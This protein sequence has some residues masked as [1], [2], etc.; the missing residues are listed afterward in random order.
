VFDDGSGAALY[1]GGSFTV[2]GGTP[3][4]RI[5]KWD[6][7]S[8]SAVGSGTSG[9]V[10]ALTVFDDGSGPALYA[11]GFFSLAGGVPANAIARW[12]GSSWSALGQG[13]GNGVQG[14]ISALATFDD[15]SGPA[16]YVGG[17]FTEAG[18]VP[19]NSIAR[20]DGTS[21]TALGPGV[22]GSFPAVYSLTVFDDGSGSALYVGGEFTQAGANPAG[23][24]ARWDGVSWS[25]VGSGM[26]LGSVRQLESFDDG[27]GAKLY[28]GGLFW[29]EQGSGSTFIAS[30]DGTSWSPLAAGGVNDTVEALFSYQ[31]GSE[32]SLYAGA[33]YPQGKGTSDGTRIARW[34]GS[35]WSTLGEGI[36]GPLGSYPFVS[37]ITAFD[38]GSGPA[39]YAGGSFT[40]AGGRPAQSIARWGSPCPPK[41]CPVDING[42]GVVDFFDIAAFLLF[43]QIQDPIADWTGDGLFNFFDFAGYLNAFQDGCP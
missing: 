41:T 42:N 3:A 29:L 39:I 4:S 15:G 30:W 12:D 33:S 11:A 23:R 28:A 40:K 43:Y 26:T 22:S 1:V 8:W 10:S 24:V 25:S 17:F 38:D 6:G 9:P 35:S 34:D 19:A 2:A 20:W 14:S 13:I 36:A 18:G 5:A 31:N 37:A 16:L 27:T 32:R 7:T 21:W